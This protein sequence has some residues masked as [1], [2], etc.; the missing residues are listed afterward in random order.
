MF[1]EAMENNSE[2][3]RHR[4]FVWVKKPV[5]WQH[6]LIEI[7]QSEKPDLEKI[8]KILVEKKISPNFRDD[9]YILRH[10][11]AQQLQDIWN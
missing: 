8:K 4:Y 1:L 10:L 7:Y 11:F 5:D 9:C 3:T 6:E 2:P